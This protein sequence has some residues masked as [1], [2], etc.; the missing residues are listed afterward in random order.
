MRPSNLKKNNDKIL[1]L[2]NRKKLYD[3]ILK[4]PG[5]HLRKIIKELNFSE[6]TTRYHIEYLVKHNLI[7]KQ[8][9]DGFSRY[10][11]SD[12][13]TL[14]NKNLTP[15]IRNENSR[16]VIIYFFC[17]VCGSIKTISNVLEKDKK[18][19]SKYIKELIKADIIEI[20]PVKDGLATTSFIRC[21]K[22][23]YAPSLNEKIYRLKNPYELYDFIISYKGRFLDEGITDDI[24]SYLDWLHKENKRRPVKIRNAN[25]NAFN[26]IEEIVFEIFPHPYY[27]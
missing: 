5:V 6:G 14:K 23:S 2:K 25:K 12:T 22:M 20:A 4:Y 1:N 9:S 24:L 13:E 11:I 8:N 15:Y 17:F 27:G 19:V 7:V 26:E 3:F 10:Y 18:D 16:A 21:K